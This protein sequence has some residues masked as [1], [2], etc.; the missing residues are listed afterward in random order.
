MSGPTVLRDRGADAGFYS[1]AAEPRDRVG[2]VQGY[3][4]IDEAGML[5]QETA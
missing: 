5:D 3:P 1:G 4:M 2:Q